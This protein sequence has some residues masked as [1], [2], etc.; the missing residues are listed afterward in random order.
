M[1]CTSTVYR[2]YCWLF[3]QYNRARSTADRLL[4]SIAIAAIDI[5]HYTS[6]IYRLYCGPYCQCNRARSMADRLLLTIAIAAIDI[7]SAA[8]NVCYCST[9]T[10]SCTQRS[11]T[12]C[13]YI[14]CTTTYSYCTEQKHCNIFML[15]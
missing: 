9:V 15:Y 3:C 11:N 10:V 1:P 6:T 12:W 5:H 2:L 4:V 13:V 7:Y 14:M 8:Q